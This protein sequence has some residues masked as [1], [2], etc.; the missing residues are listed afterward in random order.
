[1]RA[2]VSGCIGT[3]P[4]GGVAWTYGHWMAGLEQLGF[5]VWYLEDI[6]A[7]SWDPV[8]QRMR[9]D[10]AYSA[11]FLA[12]ALERVC[13]GVA[14]RWHLLAPD[15]TAHGVPRERMLEVVAGADLLLDVSGTLLLREEYLACARKV[16]ID[17]DPGWNHFVMFPRS[18]E[19]ADPP[20]V[21]GIRA[22]DHFFT[23]ARRIGRP[24][25]PLPDLGIDWQPTRP[26]VCPELWP[27]GPPGGRWTT[28]M[29]WD[30]YA[31]PILHAGRRY[32]A[33]ELEFPRFEDLPRRVGAALEVAVGGGDPPVDRWRERG[34]RVRDAYPVSGTPEAFHDYVRASRGEF[35]IIKNVYVATRSGWFSDRSTCYLAAGRPVVMQDTGFPDFDPTGAGLLAFSDPEGARAAIAEVEGDYDHHRETARELARTHFSADT[36]LTDLL[37]RVGL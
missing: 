14:A 2:V 35:S 10:G 25:C 7:E 18:L 31:Q 21:A 26:P 28:V 27:P 22:Y 15:G 24:G 4:V 5:E 9:G 37:A 32:G 3:C 30:N 34:W 16:L 17:T 8:E 12:G 23:F 36:V 20:G 11:S 1:M 29:S 19:G 13:P 33:R 6:G